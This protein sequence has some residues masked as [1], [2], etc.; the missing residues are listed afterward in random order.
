[1]K[2]PDAIVVMLGLNDRA[3]LRDKTPPPPPNAKRPV[4]SHCC[5]SATS[6]KASLR[7]PTR[8]W[9]SP[10]PKRVS[11]YHF[12]YYFGCLIMR[13]VGATFAIAALT[14]FFFAST[15]ATALGLR[16]GPLH[17]GMPF[18]GHRHHHHPL[19]MHGNPNGVDRHE[20]DRHEVD[21]HH[22]RAGAQS[23]AT[24]ALLYPD[25]AL[26]AIFQNILWP[27]FSSPWPFGYDGIFTTAFATAPADRSRDE[28]RQSV[29]ANT[30]IERLQA[31]IGPTG[32]QMEGLQRLGGAIAA[33]AGY[34]AKSCPTDI[35]QQPAARLQLMD[36]Q[37]QVLTLAID[38]IHQPLQNFEQSLTD[39]QQAKFSGGTTTRNAAA[40]RSGK[41]APRACGTSSAA[42][43][44]SINQID[45]TVQPTEE[46]RAALADVQQAFGKAASDLQAHCPTSMPR[47]A[48]ARL[49]TI[50]ARLDATWR[51][52]LSIQVALQ[53]FETTLRDDQKSRFK[54]MTFAA[55]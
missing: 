22:S 39:E 11:S 37:I 13:K 8:G 50:E 43:D 33:A 53:D 4:R 38:M 23:P 24:L 52:V 29:D 51:A 48:V 3:P 16:I 7:A 9:N 45:K 20:V 26:P 55:E 54:T 44:W 27:A 12:L 40:S 36:S 10:A 47:S 5:V 25:R 30:I 19:Y 17:L 21:R 49:E 31:E 42:I 1:M 18:F 28:C 2:K 15:P 32:Q 34:L 46:Q 14:T 35:P 6:A 41:P